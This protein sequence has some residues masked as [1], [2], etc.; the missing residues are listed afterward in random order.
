MATIKSFLPLVLLIN[1]FPFML[2]SSQVNADAPPVTLSNIGNAGTGCS[3]PM[4][5]E[6]IKLNSQAHSIDIPFDQY[7]MAGEGKKRFARKKCDVS[8][9]FTVD[10]GVQVGIGA[11]EVSALFVMDKESRAQL[12][13]EQFVAGQRGNKASI[14]VSQPHVVNKSLKI[15]EIQWAECGSNTIL[16]A[17]ISVSATVKPSRL[18]LVVNEGFKV[19]VYYRKC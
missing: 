17:K 12:S 15:D 1:S 8:L 19:R 4:K 13:V 5:K 6:A 3:Q 11:T 9:S 7:L 14:K 18:A 10:P 2:A 16:R